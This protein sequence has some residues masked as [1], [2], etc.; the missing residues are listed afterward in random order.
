M[1]SGLTVLRAP[2]SSELLMVEHY[3]HQRTLGYGADWCYKQRRS[4]HHLV[5]TCSFYDRLLHLWTP[6]TR[7]DAGGVK[8]TAQEGLEGLTI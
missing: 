3:E 1:L 4:G 2:A 6:H 8:L 7:E 5:A